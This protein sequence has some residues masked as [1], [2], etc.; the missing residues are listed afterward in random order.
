MRH[1]ALLEPGTCSVVDVPAEV[2][3][4]R[5]P[6][7]GVHGCPKTIFRC[8]ATN[9]ATVFVVVVGKFTPPVDHIHIAKNKNTNNP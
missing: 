1:H 2:A 6:R 8:D 9:T 5:A 7:L 4:V 3:P